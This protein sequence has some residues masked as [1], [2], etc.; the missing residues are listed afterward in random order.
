MASALRLFV[1]KG[2]WETT[3]RDVAAEAGFTNPAI[4]K[5]FRSREHLAQ[6]VFER[7]YERLAEALAP[8]WS[9]AGFESR[10]CRLVH[11]ASAFMDRDL[12]AFLF[13]TEHL[14][15]FWPKTPARLKRESIVDNLDEIFRQA[16]DDGQVSAA[17]QTKLL[18]AAVVGTLS[19]V[20][21]F[22]YFKEVRGPA[23]S[24]VPQLT[25]IFLQIAK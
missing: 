2:V 13:V 21:R 8:A 5:F 12:D 15:A 10:M 9:E 6:S 25:R 24:L 23:S 14:R 11:E 1:A 4:F 16:R 7:C 3:I 18:V 22:L 20:G 17:G 19:Q